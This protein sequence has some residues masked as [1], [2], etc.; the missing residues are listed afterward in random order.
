MGHRGHLLSF[1]PERVWRGYPGG[2]LLDRLEGRPQP[3]DGHFPEDWIGSVTRAV[4]PGREGIEEGSARAWW[5]GGETGFAELL[6][7]DP[8]YLLGPAHTRAFGARPMLLT[9]LLDSAVRLHFQVHPTGAFARSHGLG[10]SGKAEA[11]H[12]LAIRPE[13]ADPCIYLGFQRPPTRAALRQMIE[14][15]DLAGIEACFDRIPVSPG[16]TWFIPGGRPHAI[17]PGI[18]MVEVMEPSDLAVRFEFE[19]AGY[20]LPESARFM[21]RGLAFCLDVFDWNPLPR[22]E[23]RHRFQ[24]PARRRRGWGGAGEQFSL[25]E[26]DRNPCFSLRQSVFAGPS[27]WEG[28]EAFIAIVTGGR[29]RLRDAQR[30][31]EVRPFDRFFC[32]AGLERFEVEPLEAPF[33]LLECHPPAP[34]PG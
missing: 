5:P 6:A 14:R 7:S 1:R 20:V 3:R 10:P 8:D 4:N 11:Y 30:T 28:P 32:P 9:K 16:D 31:L 13:V 17:G 23:A 19:K 15:Q 24:C 22:E 25:L 34:V 26:A 21:G 12:L 29:A 18:L 27:A 33:T 2:A